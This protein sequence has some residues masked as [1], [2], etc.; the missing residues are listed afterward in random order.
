MNHLSKR[1]P[2][3]S[4]YELQYKDAPAPPPALPTAPPPKRDFFMELSKGAGYLEEAGQN[5]KGQSSYLS[6]PPRQ[7]VVYFF[8]AGAPLNT[9][10]AKFLLVL[11]V[12]VGNLRT[13]VKGA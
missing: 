11:A 2:F 6:Q 13:F 4:I 8:Q 3:L 10:N 7:A 1:I 9:E 5:S 12:F